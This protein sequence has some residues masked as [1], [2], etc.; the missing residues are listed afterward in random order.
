MLCSVCQLS[1]HL[2]GQKIRSRTWCHIF[3]QHTSAW[4]SSFPSSA[5][6][7]SIFHP[8][9][10]CLSSILCQAVFVPYSA[11]LSIYIPILC[12]TIIYIPSL[13][14]AVYIPI[15]LLDCLYSIPLLDCL[16]SILCQPVFVPSSA[17]LSSFL[18]CARLSTLHPF[19]RLSTFQLLG[20]IVYIPSL[21]QTVYIFIPLLGCLYSHFPA[22]CLYS[23][24]STHCRIK[25]SSGTSPVALHF[26]YSVKIESKVRFCLSL[27]PWAFLLTGFIFSS[28]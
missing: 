25:S 9:L 26:T 23:Y 6:L 15:P 8:L 19:A 16:Y 21:C 3:M 10:S 22:S 13:C 27:T 24:S 18:S 4:L 2:L 17:K 20:R 1:L 12:Q 14:Q 28:S 7:S 11:W 5:R